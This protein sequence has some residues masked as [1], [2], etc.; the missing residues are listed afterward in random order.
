MEGVFVHQTATVEKGARIGKGTKVWHYA[1][2]REGASIGESCVLG[3]C[4][5]VDANVSIGRGVK[6]GNKASIFQG[7][8]VEDGAFI[9]PHACF[10]NDPRPRSAGEWKIVKTL[11]RE[12]ASIGA[13]ST[14]VC[15]VTIGR[16]AMA[17]AG[18]VV[19]SDVPDNGLV[20]G[21]PAKLRGFVCACGRSARKKGESGGFVTLA[22][23]GCG[24]E[25]RVPKETFA[26]AE[27]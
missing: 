8:T 13:N 9:G 4:A 15:G 17:G 2:V 26:S 27:A 23:P 20:Y 24:M 6:I 5:F 10:T 1:H 16:H 22:C 25:T 19:T 21:N 18:S 12:G 3:H 11:V 14:V 7:V